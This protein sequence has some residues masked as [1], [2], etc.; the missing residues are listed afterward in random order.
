M[1]VQVISSNP[2][3]AGWCNDCGG[4]KKEDNKSKVWIIHSGVGK[5]VLCKHCCY[6]L[7]VQ[8]KW[9]ENK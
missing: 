9:T 3:M 5:I 8:L 7:F 4:P 6:D 2:M 1:S